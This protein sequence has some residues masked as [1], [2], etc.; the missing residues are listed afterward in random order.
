[1]YNSKSG[2]S[3]FTLHSIPKGDKPFDTIHIDHYGPLEKTT[4]GKIHIFEIIDAFTKFIKLFAIKSTKSKEVVNCLKTYFQ[5]YRPSRIVSDRGTA[6]TS[7][8]LDDFLKIN[9]ITHVKV[10]GISRKSNRQIKRYNRDLI[11]MFSKFSLL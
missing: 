5:F 7:R 2:K 9:N 10:A 11:P 3:E 1:M 6:F 8:E 4:S